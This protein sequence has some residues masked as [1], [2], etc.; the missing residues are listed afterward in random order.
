MSFMDWIAG[1]LGG[2][3]TPDPARE[4]IDL[5]EAAIVDR[6][7]RVSGKTPQQIRAEVTRRALYHIQRTQQT[8]R[9]AQAKR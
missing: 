4:S 8:V 6:L 3:P 7:A 2:R 5:Q 9:E 1:M